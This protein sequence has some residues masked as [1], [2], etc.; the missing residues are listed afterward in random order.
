[1]ATSFDNIG[2]EGDVRGDYQITTLYL[3]GYF[4]T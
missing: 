4:V 3:L 2:G 1:M